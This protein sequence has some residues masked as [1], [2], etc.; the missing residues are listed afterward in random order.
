LKIVFEGRRNLFLTVLSERLRW[1]E[2]GRDSREDL[3]YV[4]SRQFYRF[5]FGV[6][7]VVGGVVVLSLHISAVGWR[8]GCVF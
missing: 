3:F 1:W 6:I 4:L 7:V 2:E 8:M 5:T